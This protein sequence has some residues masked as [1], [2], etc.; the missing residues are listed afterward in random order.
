MLPRIY[1]LIND[2]PLGRFSIVYDPGSIYLL[3]NDQPLGRFSIVY[4]P[5]YIYRS[6]INL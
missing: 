6:T 3:I 4:D 1:L 2:Q 5:G